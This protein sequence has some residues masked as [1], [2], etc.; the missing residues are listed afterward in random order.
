MPQSATVCVRFAVPAPLPL[1]ARFDG[2]RL[3]SDGGLPWLEEADAVLGLCGALDG[4][5]S[6][7]T[8]QYRILGAGG[9]CIEV[10]EQADIVRDAVGEATRLTGQM[11]VV[12]RGARR[13]RYGAPAVLTSA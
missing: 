11:S 5:A 7:W 2:G 6:R 3:T 8:A 9:E 13:S 4:A 10:R 1:E 12:G